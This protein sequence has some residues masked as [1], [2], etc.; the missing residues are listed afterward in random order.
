[1]E[2]RVYNPEG[3]ALRR[4][5]LEL[6]SM[7]KIVD[8]ICQENQIPWW[9]SSGTLLGAARHKG[10]IPW[11]DDMDIVM[12]RKDYKRLEKIL[13]RM[14]NREFVFHCP[15]TD[16]EYVNLFGKFRKKEGRI[17]SLNPRNVRYRWAGIGLDIFCIEKTNYLSAYWADKIYSKLQWRTNNIS[18]TFLRGIAIRTVENFCSIIV[19]PVLRLVGLVNP[20]GEYHYSLGTGWPR[21]TF[22]M[23]FI[24]PLTFTDFEGVMMPVPKDMDGYLSNVYGNWRVPPTD[25]EIMRS[26]HCQEYRDEIYGK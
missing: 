23:K 6:L 11:D 22:Y 15:K 2:K 1:M 3:S 17:Q 19:F 21:H 5:Q 18:S 12:F 14:D 25:E 26:I 24:Y 9:L 20:R 16:V 7:L 13:C 10:F 8:G 4:D